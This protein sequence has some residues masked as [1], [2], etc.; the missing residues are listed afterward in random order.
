[1][2]SKA[3]GSDK[4]GKKEPAKSGDAPASA[5]QSSW[6]RDLGSV[7]E[8]LVARPD[9]EWFLEPVDPESIGLDDYFDVGVPHSLR[10]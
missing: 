5:P 8:W 7:L 4:S 10:L 1:M 9:A 3:T 6:K 2:A